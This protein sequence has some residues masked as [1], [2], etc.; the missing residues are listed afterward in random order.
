MKIIVHALLSL[1]LF[2]LW[3]GF[4][5]LIIN[6]LFHEDVPAYIIGRIC[7]WEYIAFA[8]AIFLS[9]F[10]TKRWGYPEI[11]K[12]NSKTK[13]KMSINYAYF[14]LVYLTIGIIVAIWQFWIFSQNF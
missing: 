5:L 3:A 10:I 7:I 11:L 8:V 1:L 14:L 6:P 9:F 13:V 4:A 12:E 2:S